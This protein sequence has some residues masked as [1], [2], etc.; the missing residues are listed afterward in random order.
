MHFKIVAM[1]KSPCDNIRI[2]FV[3]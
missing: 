3:L 2:L 1:L